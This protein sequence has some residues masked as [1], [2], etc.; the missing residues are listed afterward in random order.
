MGGLSKFRFDTTGMC[1]GIIGEA[2]YCVGMKARALIVCLALLACET[3]DARKDAPL[4]KR[5]DRAAAPVGMYL[6]E[7][8]SPCQVAGFRAAESYWE[9]LLG[10]DF[11]GYVAVV[12]DTHITMSYGT[13]K[14][15]VI[16]VRAGQM[17]T[18]EILDQ[19]ELFPTKQD[20][21]VLHSVEITTQG[22]SL[23]AFTHELGHALGLGHAEGD[24]ALMTMVH[25]ADAWEV[26]ATEL[27][28][29]R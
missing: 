12:P 1:V 3:G 6:S 27:Q 16:A 26:S 17:N 5:W 18:P 10:E 9:S 22:C 2:G 29:L 19:A 20:S 4:L 21:A 13:R 24:A 25:R 23:R 7:N 28:L 14:R 8:L 15:N 11:I